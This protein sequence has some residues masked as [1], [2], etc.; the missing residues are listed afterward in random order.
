MTL[1]VAVFAFACADREATRLTQNKLVDL[2][3]EF[4]DETIFWVTAESFKRKTV[5]EGVTD[6]GFYYS[7]YDLSGAEHGGTHIDSPVHFA[8]GK[9]TVD[10]IGLNQLV[11][12]GIKIDVSKKQTLKD[13][14]TRSRSMT[15]LNGKL[16]MDRS[17]AG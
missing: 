12:E 3:Y 10:Q 15:L 17:L 2:T 8:E 13:A 7:A 4:S 14:I 11:G 9:K 1:M 6:K 5:A 16:Q